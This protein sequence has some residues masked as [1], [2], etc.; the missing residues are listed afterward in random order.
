MH[1]WYCTLVPVFSAS[2]GIR[3]QLHYTVQFVDGVGFCACLCDEYD[4]NR[5]DGC[6]ECIQKTLFQM[7]NWF[8]ILFV[9]CVEMSASISDVR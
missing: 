7:V 3:F 8:C 5:L 6:I 9:L 4:I 2:L 1:E